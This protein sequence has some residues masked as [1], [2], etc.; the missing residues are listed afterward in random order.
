ME[1]VYE[2]MRTK[3][4]HFTGGIGSFF[5][6]Y[7]PF[8]VT[9]YTPE[10]GWVVYVGEAG[11]G[12]SSAAITGAFRALGL[13]A[14]QF[15]TARMNFHAGSVEADGERYYYNGN[16]FLGRVPPPLPLC[17]L[18]RTLEQVDNYEYDRDCDK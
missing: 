1:R 10:L 3:L 7:Q 8:T 4:V 18:F 15:S 5:D 6:I 13:K 9:P 2:Y 17:I 12:A 14:E 11:S 16:D